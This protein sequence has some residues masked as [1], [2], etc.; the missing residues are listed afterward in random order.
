MKFNKEFYHFQ[1]DILQKFESERKKGDKK[2][3]IVAP[4]GSGK[5]I[6]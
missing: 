6:I 4:P 1:K 2:I 3:H 5:T